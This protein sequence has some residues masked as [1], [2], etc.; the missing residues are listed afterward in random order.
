MAHFVAFCIIT[1]ASFSCYRAICKTACI[2]HEH[3]HIGLALLSIHPNLLV[4]RLYDSEH[5][6]WIAYSMFNMSSHESFIHSIPS[7]A[8]PCHFPTCRKLCFFYKVCW[9][10]KAP[11]SWY[12]PESLSQNTSSLSALMIFQK[13]IT[14]VIGNEVFCAFMK[15]NV[16]CG[17]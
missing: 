13:P 12:V 2:R 15:V 3:T 4:G 7:H 16:L 8:F 1:G 11:V 5:S 6:S 10:N 9:G 17:T 14:F